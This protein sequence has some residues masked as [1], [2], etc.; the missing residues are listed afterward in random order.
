M[1][2]KENIWLLYMGLASGHTF[3]TPN[4]ELFRLDLLE[5]AH[6]CVILLAFF[7]VNI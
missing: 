7:F 6:P 2:E 3:G 1:E 5:F 4:F